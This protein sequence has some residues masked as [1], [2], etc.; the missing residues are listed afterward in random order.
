MRQAQHTV[1]RLVRQG[2]RCDAGHYRGYSVT[3]PET[4]EGVRRAVGMLAFPQSMIERLSARS[5]F[6]DRTSMGEQTFHVFLRF[7]FG[8]P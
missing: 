3:R 8:V 1:T 2:C 6:N 4:L 7:V 5:S